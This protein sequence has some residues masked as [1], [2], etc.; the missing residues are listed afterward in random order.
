[1]SSSSFLLLI[2]I[3]VDFMKEAQLLRPFFGSLLLVHAIPLYPLAFLKC[4]L[5]S[6]RCAAP[7]QQQKTNPPLC[8]SLRR[9][10]H[11]L[12]TVYLG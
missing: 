1:M 11:D 6:R 5:M 8:A 2:F 7:D 12:D 9:S 4:F 3:M 10:A